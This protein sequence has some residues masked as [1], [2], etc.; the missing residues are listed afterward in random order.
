[1]RESVHGLRNQKGLHKLVNK[2]GSV[3]AYEEIAQQFKTNANTVSEIYAKYKRAFELGDS[4]K[5]Q[6]EYPNNSQGN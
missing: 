6:E 5:A 3:G 2:D 1:M 4:L